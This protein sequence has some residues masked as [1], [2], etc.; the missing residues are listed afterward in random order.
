MAYDV[1]KR[2]AEWVSAQARR[3]ERQ[4]LLL[5]VAALVLM[6]IAL[7]TGFGLRSSLLTLPIVLVMYGLSRVFDAKDKVATRWMEGARA[8]GAV[9]ETL[10]ELRHNGY[11]VMHDIEQR[12]EGNVDHL[13]S[14][15][16]GV[17]MIDTKAHAYL[18]DHLRKAKRQAAK[19][20][21]RL[22]VWVT[23]VICIHD[24]PNSEPYRDNGVW[25]VPRD[26]LLDWIQTQRNAP[27]EFDRLARFADGL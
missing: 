3:R 6:V 12:Y 26:A 16:T 18:R 25:I 11:T 7:L 27:L 21:D 4:I 15:P 24:R 8:E 1:S 20:H 14:G 5:L 23:P 22:G 2:P 17:Y 13:V 9:G 10:N 19:L